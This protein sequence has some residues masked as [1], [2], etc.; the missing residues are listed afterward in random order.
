[1][2]V[3]RLLTRKP[4]AAPGRPYAASRALTRAASLPRSTRRR[5]LCRGCSRGRV[6]P[7]STGPQGRLSGFVRPSEHDRTLR[8]GIGRLPGEPVIVCCKSEHHPPNRWVISLFARVRIFSARMRQCIAVLKRWSEWGMLLRLK[9]PSSISPGKP[10]IT[11]SSG[12]PP[13]RVDE[14]RKSA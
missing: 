5:R 6:S 14:A 2:A 3:T 1:V 4:T 7:T 8:S 12:V 9:W 13:F 10:A 11:R